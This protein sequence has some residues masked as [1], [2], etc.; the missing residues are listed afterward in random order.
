MSDRLQP[1]LGPLAGVRAAWAA[2]SARERRLVAVAALALALLLL[3]LVAIAPAMRTLR[4]AP[5]QLDALDGQLQAMQR[6]AGEASELRAVPAL[7]P[8]QAGAALKAA[9][10]RLG[11]KAK[12]SLQGDR[13]VLSLTGV[14]QQALR[15]CLAEARA[16]ARAR[17]VE[18]TLAR[19]PV[20]YSGSLVLALG[21]AP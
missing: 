6:L 13:A 1:L 14:G 8:G 4:V 18:A 21:A 9:V 15:E 19:S 11:D 12:L 10:D 2:R 17:T 20:G 16:T 3:W 5:A 7:A